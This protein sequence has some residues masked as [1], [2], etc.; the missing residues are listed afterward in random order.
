MS[1]EQSS[2]NEILQFIDPH[3][4][5]RVLDSDIS[6]SKDT[7]LTQELLNMKKK[8]LFKTLLF[9]E[10]IKFTSQNKS[11]V[12]TKET[13]AIESKKQ[14]VTKLEEETK[15]NIKGFLNLMENFRKSNNF[16]TSSSMH[17]KIVNIN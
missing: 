11:L 16:D 9:N 8:V 12:D 1:S 3:L 4:V 2:K 6:L 10:Q 14:H 13:E 7:A 17:K 5:I 15:D